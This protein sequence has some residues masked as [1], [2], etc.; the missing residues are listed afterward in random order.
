MATA[1]TRTG[2]GRHGRRRATAL[3]LALVSAVLGA[4]L[5]AT[6]GPATA[7]AAWVPAAGAHFNNPN[8]GP[9]AQRRIEDVAYQA[10]QHT[11]KGDE[12]NISL[13]SFD[14]NRM[15]D[16]LIRAYRRG[17]AVQLLLNQHQTTAVM[18]KLRKVLG[19]NR[20]RRSFIY[21]CERGCRGGSF[22]HSK[23]Y[24]FSRSGAASNVVMVGSNNFTFN[25][26]VHQWND[27][28][29]MNDRPG[30][31]RA[32]KTVFDQM[33]L[34]KR[35]NPVYQEFPISPTTELRALPFPNATPQN[36]PIMKILRQ[37]KCKG[38][39][40][41]YGTNGRTR[42][43]V[44]QHRW[45]G[46]RGAWI[47]RRMVQLYGQGC[48]IKL[49]HGSA[50]APVKKAFRTR[51]SRGYV[52]LRANGFDYDRDGF[53]DTYTHHKYMTLSGVYGDSNKVDMVLTGSSNWAGIGVTGDEVIFTTQSTRFRR[54]YERNWN[55]IWSHAS[56]PITYRREAART[57]YRTSDG[58]VLDSSLLSDAGLLG[59]AEPKAG[60][61]NWEND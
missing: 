48:D 60:G 35:A 33:R 45:G 18:K 24:L 58:S 14:R 20:E 16:A 55:Y 21:Q 41:G 38:A 54:Q 5:V 6:P 39:A 3:T 11:Q 61:K 7:R 56:R 44:D 47:A 22:L 53:L 59:W 2:T 10:I 25:A 8:G 23:F 27:L 51:T 40:K 29:V 43:R 34:D 32:F 4:L 31:Y 12:I 49:M 37:V 9:D 42:I 30:V 52:P 13:F 28:L 57:A 46:E 15:G 17:V 19:A 1:S 36:D 50:D 26:M